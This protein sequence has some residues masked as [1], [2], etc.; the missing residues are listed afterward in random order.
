MMGDTHRLGGAAAAFAGYLA[1]QN[2]GITITNIH[3]AIELLAIYPYAI[4]GSTAP[5]MDQNERAIPHRDPFN[6]TLWHILH[7]GNKPRKH[8]S[9]KSPVYHVLAPFD[10]K[11]RSWQTHSELTLLVLAFFTWAMLQPEIVMGVFGKAYAATGPVA[12]LIG[13]GL[14]L[15][16]M[17]H[18]ILDSITKEGIPLVS[19]MIVKKVSG[20]K[21]FPD[22]LRFVPEKSQYF[23]TGDDFEKKVNSVL[24]ALLWVQFLLVLISIFPPHYTVSEL[25]GLLVKVFLP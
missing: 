14:C 4:Y 3:P 21:H 11:H 24:K 20:V 18:I 25:W 2:Q 22:R 15:G 7:L 19:G 9:K 1:V 23:K 8:M 16:L 10:C 17:S 12:A 5:D 13:V 6:K